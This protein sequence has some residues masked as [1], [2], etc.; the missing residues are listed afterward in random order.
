MSRSKA[1]GR[2][3]RQQRLRKRIVGTAS[4]PRL[5]VFRSNSHISA[6]I[7]DDGSGKTLAAASTYEKTVRSAGTT[8]NVTAAKAVGELVG[9]RASAAGVKSVVFDRGGNRYHG[10]VAALADAAREKGLEF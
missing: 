9:E 7:I 10:R 5:S 6:Q 1:V 4:R 2:R 8:S 3:I